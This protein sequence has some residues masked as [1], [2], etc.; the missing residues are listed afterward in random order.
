MFIMMLSVAGGSKLAVPHTACSKH[1][2]L[3]HLV[4]ML[5]IQGRQGLLAV[6]LATLHI[7]MPASMLAVMLAIL[8]I[9]PACVLVIRVLLFML[10][11][12]QNGIHVHTK[13]GLVVI[14][15]GIPAMF[16]VHAI[17]ILLAV[18]AKLGDL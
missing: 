6:M 16:V 10:V 17:L 4:I 7:I 15:L 12:T 14:I 2:I 11:A 18:F 1:P 3:T 13:I 5:V 9:M 8:A